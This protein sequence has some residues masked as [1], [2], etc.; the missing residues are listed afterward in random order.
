MFEG[1]EARTRRRVR[2][3]TV[4]NG[5]F[6][7]ELQ[8]AARTLRASGHHR[9]LVRGYMRL[10]TWFAAG[11]EL[12]RTAGFEVASFRDDTPW[13]STGDSI[14]FPLK[15]ARDEKLGLA[16]EFAIGVGLAADPSEDVLRYL[17]RS[18][19]EVGRYIGITPEKGS[20]NTA[21]GSPAEARG[22]AFRTRDVVRGIVREYQPARIHLFLATP[23]GG[24]LL[25]GHLWDRMPATQLYE[26]L[27]PLEGYRPSFF[28]PN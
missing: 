11:V 20:S 23:H 24:A 22:W 4:W 2:D 9:V 1:D 26:D 25:L 7:R 3:A 8:G 18:V 27:G 17:G 10:P 16:E 19:P 15:I 5:R 13:A 28:I 14:D 21:I 6:R 12:G